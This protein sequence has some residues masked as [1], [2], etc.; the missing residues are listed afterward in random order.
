M[1]KSTRKSV[2][3]LPQ[4]FQTEKNKKFLASTVDQLIEPSQL[5]KLSGYAG[6]KTAPSYKA[7]DVFLEEATADRNNYQ[8]EP[9]V[10]YKSNGENIDFASQYIDFVNLLDAEGGAKIKHDRLF[11]QDSY[12]Y[13]PPIDADKFVNYRQYYWLPAGISTIPLY[14]GTSGATV[15]FSVTNDGF[16]AYK[17]GH[18]VDGNPDIIVYKGNNYNFNIDAQGHPFHIK[19]QPGTGGDD[20]FDSA[21][22]SNSGTDK[23]V[24]TLHVPAADSSTTQDT[25]LWY[26]CENH[27]NMVGKIII[28]DLADEKFDPDENL[29]GVVAFT[30][31]KG[32]TLSNS[33]KIT[34]Q[35]D[36]TSVYANRTYFVEEV[37]EH[38]SLLANEDLVIPEA[39]STE[40]GAIW[41]EDGEEGF[42]T[43]GFDNSTGLVIKKDYWTINRAS[44]DLNAWSRSNRWVHKSVIDKADELNNTITTTSENARAKRP[45][46]EFLSGFQL[47]NHG[48]IGTVVDVI[49]TAT[50]DALSDIQG[51][52]GATLDGTKLRNGDKI[53]FTKDPDVKDKIFTID[54]TTI[55]SSVVIHLIDDSTTVPVGQSIVAKRGSS[56]KGKTYQYTKDSTWTESQ[57]KTKVQQKPLFDLFDSNHVSISDKDTYVSSSFEGTTMFEIA[58]SDQ[59]T[60]DTIYGTNVLYKRVGLINDLQINDTLN[61]STFNYVANNEIVTTNLRQ[62][63]LHRERKGDFKHT[64]FNNWRKNKI[65]SPQKVVKTYTAIEDETHFIVDHYLNADVLS[66]LNIAVLVNGVHTTAWTKLH[67]NNNVYIKLTTA[68]A[69]NDIVTVKAHSKTGTPSGQGHF[70]VPLSAQRNPLNENLKTFTLGDLTKHYSSA[71]EEAVDFTGTAV[72][73]NSSRDIPHIFEYGSVIMQHSGSQPLAS[74]FLKDSVM[75]LPKAMRFSAREYEKFKRSI[76]D[77]TKGL[78]LDGLDDANLDTVIRQINK[79]KTSTMAFYDTDMLAHGEDQTTLKYT[80][81]DPSVVYYPITNAF[82]LATLSTK[83]VYVY[84]NNVQL[85]HGKDYGFTKAEDSSNQIGIE[86]FST[87]AVDDVLKVVEHNTTKGSYVPATPAK[88]GLAP[89]YEPL[90]FFDQ[91]YQSEDSSVVGVEVVRG[92]D[93]SITIAYGDFRDNLLLEF[94]K[95]IYNNIKVKYNANLC[96]ADYGYFRDNEYTIN[97]INKTFSR[98]FYYWTGANAV[99]YTTNST[100]DSG[101]DF[102]YNYSKYVD[103]INGTLLQ[104]YWRNIYKQWFDTDQPHFAPWEMVGFSVKPDYWDAVYGP[105]PYTKGNTILWKDM[106]DGFIA[107]GDRKGYYTRYK[108]SPDVISI[109]P[110]TTSGGIAPPTNAG[111]IGPSTVTQANQQENFAFGDHAPA[112]TAWRRSSGFRFAEQVSKFLLKPAKYAGLYFDYS[113]YSTD[114][115]G[116]IV[117]NN[118]YRTPPSDLFLP[119]GTTLTAGFVNTVFDYVKSLG[120][121]ADTYIANRLDN[122]DVQMSYKLAGFSNKDNLQVMIGAVSPTSQNRSV[123]TPKENYDLLVHTSAPVV[124]ANYS[125]VIVEKITDG[126]KIS[127]YSNFDRTFNYYPV[128][129]SATDFVDIIV[130][131]VTDDFTVW[132]AGGFYAKGYVVKNGSTFYRATKN[133]TSGQTFDETDW[134]TIGQV[135]PLKGG[136]RVRKYKQFLQNAQKLTYGSTLKSKQ[137]VANFLY[138]YAEYLRRQGFVFDDFSKELEQPLNWDLSTREFLFWTTQNWAINSVIT[139]SPAST[140]LRFVRDN[141]VGDDLT[142]YD[143]YYTVLQQDGLPISPTSL[144]TNRLDGE[145]VITTDPNE[146]G[147]YNADIRAVQKEHLLLLDNKTSFSDIVYDPIIGN[148]Q[149]RIKLVGFRTAGWNGDIYTPGSILDRAEVF[150]WTVNT[151][152]K[153]GNIVKHQNKIYA[154]I[155]NHNAGS[156]FDGKNYRIKDEAPGYDLLPNWDAKAESFRDFYSL[157]SDNFNADQQKFAQHL[158]GYQRRSYFDD[159]GIDELTQYK[160]YQGMIRD[161]GTSSPILRFKSNPQKLQTNTYDIFEEYAFRVGEYGGHRTSKEYEFALS[162]RKHKENR[163]IYK[164]TDGVEDDTQ[165]IINVSSSELVKS[166]TEFSTDIFDTITYSTTGQYPNAIFEY[167]IAGYVQPDTVDASVWSEEELLNI[168]P[169]LLREGYRVWIANTATGDWDV[170]RFNTLSLDITNYE[171][172]DDKLQFTTS[173]P[174]GLVEGDLI[175]IYGFKSLADGIYKM[176]PTVDSTDS[177]IKFTVPFIGTPDSTTSQGLLGVFKTVRVNDFDDLDTIEPSKRWQFG[178]VVY[179][180]NDYTTNGGLWKIYQKSTV[181]NAYTYKP[182]DVFDEVITASAEFGKKLA[183][184]SDGLYL[185]VGAPGDNQLH[186]YRRPD[187]ASSFALRNTI[188]HTQ[189]NDDDDDAFGTDVAMTKDGKRVFVGAPFTSDVVKLTVSATPE[190]FTRTTVLTGG[191]STATGTVLY[192]DANADVIYVKMTSTADFVGSE[193]LG[194]ADSS[195]LVTVTKVQGSN[196]V[197][198]GVVHVMKA[199][200]SFQ[201]GLNQIITAPDVGTG[202]KFGSAIASSDDGT[203]LVIGAPGGPNDSSLLNQGTVYVYKYEADG[204]SAVYTL[205][206][207]LTPNNREIGEKYGEALSISGDGNTIIVGA[208]EHTDSTTSTAGKVYVF[209]QHNGYF[210]ENESLTS[211]I[212][213]ED[214]QFGSSLAISEDGTDVMVGAPNENLVGAVTHFINNTST[215]DTDGSTTSF[216]ASFDILHD[217]TELFVSDGTIIYYPSANDSTTPNYTLDGSTNIIVLSTAPEIGRTLTIKQYNQHKKIKEL[218][219]NTSTGFG[220]NITLRDGTMAV[221]ALK[222]DN[223]RATTFDTLADDSSTALA[224]TTFDNQATAF[225]DIIADTGSV[226]VFS[227]YDQSFI[228]DQT[229]A[230]GGSLLSDSDLFGNGLAISGNFIYVGA[231]S[232]DVTA[233]NGGAV[234]KFEKATD[235]KIWNTVSTQPNLIDIKNVKKLFG[236]DD[237]TKHQL[238]GFE[239]IDPAKGRLFSEVEKNISYKTPYRP[240]SDDWD[241]KQV[242]QIWF[243]LSKIKFQWYEQ[244]DLSYKYTNWGK[245]HPGSIVSMSEWT[246]SDLTPAEWNAQALSTDGIAKGITG[247]ADTTFIQKATY[248]DN[249]NVFVDK[250]YYWVSNPTVL[251][252]VTFRTMTAVQMANAVED[253]KNFTENFAA[254]IDTN[255][256]LINLRT[257]LLNEEDFILHI[258]TT[259]DDNQLNL[260]TEHVLVAKGDTS[261]EIPTSLSTK[262]HDSIVG[263]DAMGKR[264]PDLAL[265]IKMRYGTLNRPRQSWYTSPVVVVKALTQFINDKLTKKAYAT[266]YNLDSLNLIDPIPNAKLNEYNITVDT[267][268]DLG[269]LETGTLSTGYKA[270]VKTDSNAQNNWRIYTWNGSV[271]EGFKS[272]SYDTTKY[273]AL[274]DWYADGYD[275]TLTPTYIIADE[276]TRKSTLYDTGTIVKVQTSYDGNFRV[277]IK[278]FNDWDIIGIG[279]G[280]IKLDTSLYDFTGSNLGFGGDAYDYNAYDQ[281]AGAELRYILQWIRDTLKGD[282]TLTYN[283]IFF[284]GIR[285][286]QLQH[287]DIDWA[288]KSSFV[289]VSNTFSTLSQLPEYQIETSDAVR[290]FLEEVLPFKTNIREENTVYENLESFAGDVTDFDNKTYYDFDAKS[291]VNPRTFADDS[292]YFKV[293]NDNPWKQYSDNYKYNIGSIIVTNAGQGYNTVPV[294]TITGGG[295]SGATATALLGNGK[296]TSIK[297]TSAGSGYTSTPTVTITGGGGASVTTPATAYAQLTNNKIRSLDTAIKFDRI[298]SLRQTSTN[299]ITDWTAF[300]QYT[301]GSNIRNENEIYYVEATFTS[302]N[303]FDD[304]VLLEDSSSV[305]SLAPIRKWTATD[306]IHAYYDPSVGMAGLIGDGSTSYNAYAQLMTGLEYKGVRVLSDGFSTGAT[307][308]VASYDNTEYD[309]EEVTDASDVADITNFDQLLDSKTF[310]TQL[311]HRAEDI[312]VVGDAFISEYSANAPEEVVPGGVYDTVD[313]KVYTQPS[314]GASVIQ[315]RNHYGDGSTTVFSIPSP[316]EQSGVRVFVNNQFQAQGADYSINYSNNTITFSTAPLDTTVIAIVV[317]RVSVD[318]LIAEFNKTGDGSTVTFNVPVSFDT[319]EQHYVLSNGQKVGV[320]LSP[321]TDSASTDVVF[322]TAPIDD[323]AISIYLFDLDPSEK[324]FSEVVSTT[325]SRNDDSSTVI[326]HATYQPALASTSVLT[327]DDAGVRADAERLVTFEDSS[328]LGTGILNIQLTELPSAIG[329][330]HHKAIVEGVAGS[331]DTN[332]YRLAPPQ[333]RFHQGD[334]TSTLFIIPDE[335]IS[336]SGADITN[337]EVWRNGSRVN[338]SEYKIS[339]DGTGEKGVLFDTAPFSTDSIA[340]VLKLGHDYEIDENGVLSLQSGFS[341]GSTINNDKVVVTTFTNH[342]KMGMRTETFL[343]STG[344]LNVLGEDYGPITDAHTGTRD[345]GSLGS[346]DAVAIDFGAVGTSAF[347]IADISERKY[348]LHQTPVNGDYVFV[349]LNKQYLTSNVD[350]MLSGKTVSIPRRNLTITDQ[351]VISY[352]TA[353]SSKPAI[354]YRIFKDILNRYH[355]R[356]MSSNHATTLAKDVT[357]DSTTIQVVDGSVLPTPSTTANIPGI[358][359]IGSERIGYFTKEGNI[360]SNLFRGTLG[361]GVQNH[362]M[363]DSVVDASMNQKVPY[364]DV[365][366]TTERT[367]DGSTVTYQIDPVEFTVIE[368]DSSTVTRVMPPVTSKDEVVVLLGGEKTTAFTLGVDSARTITFDTAP[369]LGIKIRITTKHGEMWLNR[370]SQFISAD[371]DVHTVDTTNPT[372][373]A[374][375]FPTTGEG[376]QKSLSQPV[377]FLQDAPTDLTLFN[378]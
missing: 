318:N 43:T 141:T 165:Q 330:Y 341:D 122:L 13:A 66:D 109:I 222:G 249:K 296:I 231:P 107:G 329:P 270:L 127:G 155:K 369:A 245:L 199:D 112:E 316:R 65:V 152:Y 170:K 288:F 323:A 257:S 302:G 108:R 368:Q 166:P 130:G 342:D 274:S 262:F 21:Y 306:R 33:M 200:T 12:S 374:T 45:I 144:S 333:I 225:K 55:S 6:I 352:I 89:A 10:T 184:S 159:L 241:H 74:V 27:V 230:L 320:T 366:N 303:T 370:S 2:N 149:D 121:T 218:D 334:G 84:L 4:V 355:Y 70:E 337:V 299:T 179:V 162:E 201:F 205:W 188:D 259:T 110:V 254:I 35:S 171:H 173:S 147:I 212:V 346:A 187:T 128:K 140:N 57:Q 324:A 350:Y 113:R 129:E 115:L 214:A 297:V 177:N 17:F 207:T 18:K 15:T 228:F 260:H 41:D 347:S 272:Q 172:F 373:D 119:S 168:D 160:F 219:T 233:T 73:D 216:T 148:R 331:T 22:V 244:D 289:K 158:I 203:F 349:S 287:K 376:L 322:P 161:K 180:D 328:G 227:K 344:A 154:V 234:Y 50:T 242:G 142:N 93:G 138:G 102:T 88:L 125:G 62:F 86:I 42:D 208:P 359:C 236:Y 317:I 357:I 67:K 224:G 114:A 281:Q 178:D 310:T 362:S 54:F 95:R 196:G 85:V 3:L 53:V 335:P 358:I 338:V 190:N 97:E 327:A 90:K 325:Y 20:L 123:F 313:I 48:T 291:Y 256:I 40:K 63:H 282:D 292:T 290:E 29:I 284:L 371:T 118:T 157:D 103:S 353:S 77:L 356:R 378:L 169:S 51:Q 361:T 150:D 163:Q 229:L 269:F 106:A 365:E 351:V 91:T 293:Y 266:L 82:D 156:I 9:T 191:T 47:Y 217:G 24:V 75:N 364:D 32:L 195:S 206:Q 343:G 137:D 238:T 220:T 117:Y 5:E 294:V 96:N 94:E 78:S 280:T 363:H 194:T 377:Q 39:F 52:T 185:A 19:T 248:D 38:I 204:S 300:T 336:N 326:S 215:H 181:S 273:W 186:V 237:L 92:H 283:D 271:W 59:G 295:G 240:D 34:L 255:A 99:D 192:N 247:T 211:G 153:I 372:A 223:K 301:A 277:Y 298:N 61:S 309:L 348:E 198:Q 226:Q 258:E 68:S 339:Q 202:E 56:N 64:F 131:A 71:T 314:D 146:N 11:E 26:Q 311:G 286:A 49:D 7:S 246:E 28:K 164:I 116:H 275:E 101:N 174:H 133:L 285:L 315:R 135:L 139:L 312:N 87:I 134:T 250:Y 175:G 69:V 276:K 345:Y 367:G 98:D 263:F 189:N 60:P 1:A 44:P 16:G 182:D 76:I 197:N 354:G 340:I 265:P 100:Y 210:V 264:V 321:G 251:P 143:E 151:D 36:V 375:T 332:R 83:A 145:F 305:S 81:V 72:G 261:S 105:A 268:T 111:I 209:R 252:D 25:V 23:G 183:V 79:N 308:D 124:T 243:D 31:Y 239:F 235:D 80:V 193:S 278:T 132:Q 8:F 304:N 37:G 58:T 232:S 267:Y 14:P 30:D 279:K 253:P 167:P 176:Q 46:V 120:Y 360:L 104:G 307:Y 136:V 213:Y 221:Y 126:F 319:I